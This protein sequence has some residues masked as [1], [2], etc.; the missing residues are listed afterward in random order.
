MVDLPDGI[1]MWTNDLKQEAVRLGN[2]TMPE[3]QGREHNALSD[4]RHN[5]AM[6]R[7]LKRKEAID[8][9]F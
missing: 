1:P 7:F 6:H 3:Q 8:R 5:L 2:P 4:A 9:G